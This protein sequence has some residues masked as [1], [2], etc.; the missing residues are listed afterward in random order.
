MSRCSTTACGPRDGDAEA[1]LAKGH[2]RSSCSARSSKAAGTWCARGKPAKQP[3][4]LLFKDKDDY[5][6]DAGSRR[7]AGRCDAA[8]GRGPQARRDGKAV[9]KKLPRSRPLRGAQAR[10][11]TGAALAGKRGKAKKTAL[12]MPSRRSWPGSAKR[13]PQGD[14]VAARDQVGRLP[15]RRR[16]SSR[17]R[18]GSGRATRSSGPTRC[19]RSPPRSKRLGLDQRR[20]RWR[21]DRRARH[22]AGFQPAAGDVVGREAGLAGLVLFDLLHLDGFDS[23]AR[24]CSS[25]RSC[26]QDCSRDPPRAPRLQLAHP[27][28][29]RRSLSA[30]GRTALRRHHLQARR[31]AYHRPQRRMAKTKRLDSDE[32][33]VVGYTAGQGQPHRLRVAAAGAAGRRH[34]WA[35][36]G[37]VGTGFSDELLRELVKAL[38]KGGTPTPTVPDDAGKPTCARRAVVRADVRGRGVLPRHRQHRLLRQPR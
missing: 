22:A 14:A 10:K 25:A 34:G 32:F 31:P 33:A 9:T 28:R 15:D 11:A 38:G 6:G 16:P 24:R 19:R 27:G 2:L 26:W 3:Q 17:A 4:W 5:A 13:R 35:Y 1:Q 37:R 12:P 7:P 8:A 36:A 29:R 18:R 20:A 21:A 23:R 30:R